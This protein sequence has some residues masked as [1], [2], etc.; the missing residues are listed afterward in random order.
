MH[1]L[2]PVDGGAPPQIRPQRLADYSEV[3]TRAVFQSGMSWTVVDRRWPDIA[4][5][6]HDFDPAP[7]A[8]EP[9]A[10]LE[11]LLEDAR[12]LRHRGKLDAVI[13]NAAALLVLEETEV[14]GAAG[15]F[16]RLGGYEEAVATLAA[17]FRYLGRF[18]ATYVLHVLGGPAPPYAEWDRRRP[19]T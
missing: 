19:S 10:Q 5:A 17:T 9:E 6:L 4:A 1:T 13:R 8:A 16:E 15:W 18:G 3:I 14:G 11:R 12:V 7:L 2:T